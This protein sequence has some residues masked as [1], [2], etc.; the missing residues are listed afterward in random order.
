MN[1]KQISRLTGVTQSY[2]SQIKAGKKKPDG[3]VSK[4]ILQLIK[5]PDNYQAQILEDP[6][7]LDICDCAIMRGKTIAVRE[8][9]AL[10]KQYI[11]TNSK[12]KENI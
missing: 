5:L 12:I 9:A 4:K 7:M 10:L 8:Y 3:N 1:Q 2:V 11:L 6:I